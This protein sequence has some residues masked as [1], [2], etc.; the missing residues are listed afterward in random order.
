MNK[1]PFITII[2]LF[3]WSLI[4]SHA[5]DTATGR[6]APLS[7]KARHQIEE[8]FGVVMFGDTFFQRLHECLS[9]EVLSQGKRL[10]RQETAAFE[11][12]VNLGGSAAILHAMSNVDVSACPVR[13]R[14]TWELAIKKFG[15]QTAAS[16]VSSLDSMRKDASFGYVAW[17]EELKKRARERTGK[18]LSYKST[19]E[20]LTMAQSMVIEGLRNACTQSDVASI[21]QQMLA[22][23]SIDKAQIAFR[24]ALS[25]PKRK[26]PPTK[27]NHLDANRFEFSSNPEFRR[28]AT[29]LIAV[30][31]NPSY[32]NLVSLESEINA[33]PESSR[34]PYKA[35]VQE[36]IAL[37]FLA[38][39]NMHAYMG[40][41]AK[42]P[43]NSSQTLLE[44]VSDPCSKCGGTGRK[45]SLGDATK[46]VTCSSCDGRGRIVDG[47]KALLQMQHLI[48]QLQTK[49]PDDH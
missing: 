20:S 33:I 5:G 9:E 27:D 14:E 47:Q 41:K 46:H 24:N 10:N 17:L 4:P 19:T 39:G 48:Q 23:D 29:E 32:G 18:E 12:F 3:V 45:A 11:T 44:G 40:R 43:G 22:P 2:G 36:I 37:G 35:T 1:H 13:F 25:A 34:S 7:A 26:T 31:E 49:E 21:V 28:L 6:P 38:I 8:A 15:D 42:L 30:Y 16:L